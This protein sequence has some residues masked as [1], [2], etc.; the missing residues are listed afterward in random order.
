LEKVS[1]VG[2]LNQ[3]LDERVVWP[4][5]YFGATHV[6]FALTLLITWIVTLAFP[7]LRP[8]IFYHPAKVI[9][10]SFNPCFGWDYA[11]ASWISVFCCSFNVFLAYR[12]AWVRNL[13]RVILGRAHGEPETWASVFSKFASYALALSTNLWLCLWLIGPNPQDMYGRDA[14]PDGPEVGW[15]TLHTGLFVFMA[16]AEYCVYLGSLLDISMG[17]RS[18]AVQTR[19]KVFAFVY[20]YSCAY[21]IFVYGYNLAFHEVG[22][23]MPALGSGAWTQVSDILWMAC[24]AS[25]VRFLPAEPPLFVRTVVPQASAPLEQDP[26][27]GIE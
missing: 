4:K 11:P 6:V 13:R 18:E 20:G 12:Y 7:T 21:L 24:L 22:S 10:G 8:Q 17:P 27:A 14:D 23:G 5:Y 25:V 2:L 16:G 19:H 3:P 15:W 26:Q 9:I 1:I